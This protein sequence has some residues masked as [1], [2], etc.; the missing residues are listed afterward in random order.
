MSDPIVG[1]V[2]DYQG[3]SILI[4]AIAAFLTVLGGFIMQVLMFI[5]QGQLASRQERVEQ[6]VTEVAKVAVTTHDLVNSLSDR[7]DKAQ[8]EAAYEQGKVV[9]AEEERANPLT[10]TVPIVPPTKES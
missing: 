9:G 6:V 5:R 1:P 8:K 10:P 3:M 2:T 7:K 4:G